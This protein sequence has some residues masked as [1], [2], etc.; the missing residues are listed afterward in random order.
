MNSYASNFLDAEFCGDGVC[1]VKLV[2]A[3]PRA[4][5]EPMMQTKLL[6]AVAVV[7]STWPAVLRAQEQPLE[8]QVV[9][10][11]NKVF[12]AHPGFRAT[13]AKGMIVEGS[14][15]GT[16]EG[17]ALSK[18]TLFGGTRIPVTVR[19]SNNGGVPTVPDGSAD[20]N[21]HG[22]AVKFRL[23][24]GSEVDM[25]MNSLK[26]FPVATA[27]D[28]RDLLEAVAASPPEAAKP[29]KL[30]QFVASHPT[31]AA[32]SATVATPA[33]FAEEQYQGINA[34][35]LVNKAGE[36]QAVRFLLAPERV[37]HL[38]PADATKRDPNFLL[39]ELA[40]RLQRA[41]V[42]FRLKAQLANPGDPTN[43]PSKPWPENRTVV[44]LGT[45][46]LDKVVADSKEAEK[47]LLFLPGQVP[48][49]VELS[50]DPMVSV[51]TSTYAESFSRR[52]R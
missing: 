46:I 19:F 10:A 26:F 45:L 36:R 31:V 14:F 47:T 13:H 42:T 41:P 43:D 50:D 28:L 29:T 40:A 18:A 16:S 25:V 11:M 8:V 24:D 9:D 1:L 44:E 52:S 5:E 23:P 3:P 4:V 27:E 48:D 7:T 17:A 6:V 12:G 32:A 15:R 39:N 22:M 34:F 49:G 38:D 2:V 20:A 35:V 37:V 30:E 51:R 33:S 21:P